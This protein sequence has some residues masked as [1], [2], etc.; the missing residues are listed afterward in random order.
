M[1]ATVPT[2]SGYIV[3]DLLL[4][5]EATP[6][7]P[8]GG[9]WE[10]LSQRA[11]VLTLGTQWVADAVIE[12]S[13]SYPFEDLQDTGPVV[14][15]AANQYQYPLATFINPTDV[16]ASSNLVPSFY[17]FYNTPN[18]GV[19]GYNPGIGLTYKSIDSLELMFST[20]GTPAYW[21]RWQNNI[22]I[23]PAPTN[24]YYCYMRYQKQHPFSKPALANDVIMLPDEWREIVEYAAAM[25]GAGNL[26]MLDYAQ[27]YKQILFGDPKKP[28][29]VGL[30]A[31]R[32]SQMESD[33]VSNQGM[34]QIRPI[35]GRW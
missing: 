23:A 20:P 19:P 13:R 29:D 34:R 30:I 14:Q 4:G 5:I 21:S 11:D 27:Q 31:A 8:T 6:D 24:A 1:G 26:R 25:R 18:P 15:M 16:I 22:Y 32:V 33:I 35:N 2:N 12:L 10:K 3:Q 17:M 9:V 7:S 28:G